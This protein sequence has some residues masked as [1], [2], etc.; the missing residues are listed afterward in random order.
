[1][2]AGLKEITIIESNIYRVDMED[3]KGLEVVLLL[4]AAAIRDIYFGNA[5]AAFHITDPGARKNSGGILGRKT[6]SPIDPVVTPPLTGRATQHPQQPPRPGPKGAAVNALYNQQSRNETQRQN[7]PPLRTGNTPN[8][9]FD[10][11]KQ[12]EI[13]AETA[14]LKA[15]V[16][17]EEREAKRLKDIERRR[18]L[19]AEEEEAKK[20]KKFLETEERERRRRQTEIDKETERLRKKYGDQGTLAP[21]Q[22]PQRHSAPTQRH[23]YAPSQPPRHNGPYLQAPASQSTFFG[24]GGGSLRPDSGQRLSS[25]QKKKSFWGLRSRSEADS[26][27]TLRK[28]QSSMF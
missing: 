9:R 4:G 26:P 19:K 20:T 11:R 18:R 8:P 5:K 24:G 27:S 23:S 7:L 13:D 17:A 25:G 12:W 3:Y 1:M 16:E 15:Q 2:F 28:K 14:R 6:S 22:Q 21:P 10:P